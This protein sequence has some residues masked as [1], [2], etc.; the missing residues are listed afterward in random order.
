MGPVE[1]YVDEKTSLSI[2]RLPSQREGASSFFGVS[3]FF[4]QETTMASAEEL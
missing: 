1:I 3:A 2:G 4:S